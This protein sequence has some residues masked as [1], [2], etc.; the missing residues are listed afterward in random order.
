MK[1]LLPVEAGEY[2]LMCDANKRGYYCIY[3]S[4][5][6]GEESIVANDNFENSAYV[7]VSEGQYLLLNRCYIE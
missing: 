7:T 4:P 5:L 3:D 1:K 2:K 6:S